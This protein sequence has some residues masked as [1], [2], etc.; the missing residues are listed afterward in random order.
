MRKLFEDIF[1]SLFLLPLVN[2][3]R[4]QRYEA[5]APHTGA[6]GDNVRGESGTRVVDEL[7]GGIETLASVTEKTGGVGLCV[8]IEKERAVDD[9]QATVENVETVL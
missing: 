8:E 9:C 5:A 1:P 3:R 7:S 4:D 2:A 6:T